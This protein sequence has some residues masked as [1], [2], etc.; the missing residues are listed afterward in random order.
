MI[1]EVAPRRPIAADLPPRDRAGAKVAGDQAAPDVLMLHHLVPDGGG[2][3]DATS[4]NLRYYEPRTAHGSSLSPAI[5]AALFARA[6][7]FESPRGTPIASRID[8][9]DL[10]G[11]TASGLHLATMGGLWQAL[12]MGFAGR[13]ARG[14]SCG[15]TRCC[16][17][18][19]PAWRCT[20]GSGGVGY[21][22]AGSN[23]ADVSA[24]PPST[25]SSTTGPTRWADGASCSV[26]VRHVGVDDMNRVI[27]AIDSSLAA[28]PVLAMA[29]AVAPYFVATV[30][31]VHV[32]EGP[33]QTVHRKPTRPV[34]IC[35]GSKASRSSRSAPRGRRRRRRPGD[36]RTLPRPRWARRP[37]TARPRLEDRQAGHRGATPR[38]RRPTGS[39]VC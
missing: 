37:P 32:V 10:T 4:P 18:P 16:P 20:F 7:D 8:L 3:G 36:R 1:A 17:G 12:V 14:G 31:A 11:T 30:E 25:S 39:V 27:A 13:G 38:R 26:T 9:D 21:R 5:H 33:D 24:E 6:R 34:S 2:A 29:K 23:G 15:S 22:S 19:G 28:G 35:D